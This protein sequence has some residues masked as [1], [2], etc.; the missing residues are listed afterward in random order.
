[1][2]K[3]YHDGRQINGSTNEMK[4][5]QK[6]AGMIRNDNSKFA[7]LPTEV[8]MKPFPSMPGYMDMHMQ[9]NITGIDKQMN[10]DHSALNRGLRPHKY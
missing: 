7:N 8:M 1:M 6:D 2:A 3:R 4:Q 5:E 10:A 9:D